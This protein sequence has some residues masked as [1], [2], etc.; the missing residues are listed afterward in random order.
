VYT[1][2][3]HP[4]R[5]EHDFDEI[6]EIGNGE[7]GKVMK[8]RSKNGDEGDVY[9]VKK[10]KRFEGSKHRYVKFIFSCCNIFALCGPSSR[11]LCF[12]FPKTS[13]FAWF[14]IMGW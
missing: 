14:L 4:G 7:F 6:E 3:E 1:E 9:A 10:S 8:V 5:F 2:E 12:T 11:L 13:V